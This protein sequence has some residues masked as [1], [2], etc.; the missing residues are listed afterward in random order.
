MSLRVHRSVTAYITTVLAFVIR[1][2]SRGERMRKVS[3]KELRWEG[4]RIEKGAVRLC[5]RLLE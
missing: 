3:V 5:E 2:A 4:S 1:A